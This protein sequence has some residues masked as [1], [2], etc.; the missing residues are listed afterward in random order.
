MSDPATRAGAF[1]TIDLDAIVDNWRTC[2]AR[3]KAGAQAAAVVKADAYG[4]G[5]DQ[6]APALRAAGCKRFVVATLD[7][8]IALRALL[9]DADILVLCGPFPGT[10]AEF[11]AHKLWPVLNSPE[12]AEAWSRFAATMDHPLPAV[13]HVDT[14]MERL[15]LSL[16]EALA[17]ADD[18][19]ILAG[20]DL[21][22][23]ISHLACADEPVHP[24]NLQ[25]L[26]R[27]TTARALFPG[28]PGSL[29]AS[30]GIFLG[31]SFHADWVRPG[32]ALYGGNPT[33]GKPNPMRPVVGLK[34]R[35]V[36]VRDVD[37]GDT[38][39]YG[40]THR[41]PTNS[42]LAIVAAGYADGLHRTLG[43]RGHGLVGGHAVP[44]VGRVSMDLSIFDIG[45][46]PEGTLAPGDMIDLI[47]PGHDI[48]A[49]ADEAQ[50]IGYELLTAL[51]RRYHRI[52]QHSA[53]AGGTQ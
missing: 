47:G 5:A 35:V 50:T 52:Y 33:P 46:L 38:V 53:Q 34:G 11:S 20:L 51:G 31:E 9:H 19:R 25:Q 22:L 27:F 48:D 26:D 36:R 7:E 8:A 29:S 18:G 14:G 43:N 6:V 12:Q 3:L 21:K 4:L 40:A 45:G 41:C 16:K 2:T 42:R 32:I 10:V 37:A 15:G 44:L 39:G 13:L 1:L 30:S 23:V 28:I 49:I 17:L 24:L